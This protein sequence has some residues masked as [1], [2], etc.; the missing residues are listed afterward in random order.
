MILALWLTLSSAF[1]IDNSDHL[2]LE[3]SGGERVEGWYLRATPAGVV[4]TV[5]ATGEVVTIPLSITKSVTLNDQ[6]RTMSDF[7]HDLAAAWTTQQAWLADPPPHPHPAIVAGSNF[8]V[9]GAGHGL[10][11]EW[12]PA[13]PMLA[14]DA[15]CMGIVGLETAGKGT[16]RIDV[17][18]TAVILSA[19]FKSYAVSDGYRR[20]KR[21]RDRLNLA[22]AT[23]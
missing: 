6:P 18:F 1:A 8:M 21:R 23:R 16:G 2:V 10:L 7:R 22:S 19:V 14:V 11:G 17:F 3:L 5:P 9:A 12:G 4:V 15:T 20:A 13:L